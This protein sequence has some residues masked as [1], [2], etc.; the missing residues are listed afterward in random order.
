VS[1]VDKIIIKVLANRLRRVV[2]KIISKFQNAFVQGGQILHSVLIAMNVWMVESDLVS[3]GCFANWI[4]RRHMIMSIWIFDLL[5]RYGFGE[6]WHSLIVHCIPLVC[7][8]VLVNGSSFGFF[9]SSRDLRSGDPVTF[10]LCY[11]DG[12]IK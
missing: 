7:F 4:L 12:G 11:Y 6:K 1:G 3:Q 8:F 5:R 10:S 9:S 2:E